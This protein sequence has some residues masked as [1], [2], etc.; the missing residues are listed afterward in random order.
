MPDMPSSSITG[1]RLV[2]T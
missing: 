1:T 2:W